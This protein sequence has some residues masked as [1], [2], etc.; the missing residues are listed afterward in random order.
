MNDS[1]LADISLQE[2]K[3]AIFQLG[4]LKSP[5]PDDFQGNFFIRI[6]GI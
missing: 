4:A 3:D 2:V 5:G 6:T 1:L